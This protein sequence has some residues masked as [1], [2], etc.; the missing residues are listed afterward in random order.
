[1]SNSDSCCASQPDKFEATSI[2][3]LSW[4][5]G[6]IE[7][8]SIDFKKWIARYKCTI[9]GQIWEERYRATGHGEIPD[10]FKVKDNINAA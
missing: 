6:H 3:E 5:T 9:C 10:V 8:V 7:R 4:L 2:K 1:M